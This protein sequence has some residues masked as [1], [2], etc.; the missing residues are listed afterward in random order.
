MTI[1]SVSWSKMSVTSILVTHD[2]E[3]AAELS[4]EIVVMNHGQIEQ[5]GDYN[6]LVQS[7]T[8]HFV[9]NFLQDS[10]EYVI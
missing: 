4:D 5:I 2:Q 10:V 1:R 8:S 3:E 7:P 9:A 6:S